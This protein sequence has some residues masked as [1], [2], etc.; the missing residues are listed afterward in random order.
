MISLVESCLCCNPNSVE[1][2]KNFGRGML[3]HAKVLP[4]SNLKSVQK[5]DWEKYSQERILNACCKSNLKQA[6]V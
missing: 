5:E 4:M 6:E 1:F 2:H 3:R